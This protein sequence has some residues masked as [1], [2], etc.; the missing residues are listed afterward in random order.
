MKDQSDV[1]DERGVAVYT[2]S[3]AASTSKAWTTCSITRGWK[4]ASSAFN[5]PIIDPLLRA[6]ALFSAADWPLSFSLDHSTPG[7]AAW[8]AT[9]TSR[10]WNHRPSRSVRHCDTSAPRQ[11]EGCRPAIALDSGTA[12]GSETCGNVWHEVSL[13]NVQAS[14]APVHGAE[15][16]SRRRS[17][18]KDPGPT[19]K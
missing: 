17:M 1:V 10:P 18:R 11:S 3:A 12:S 7:P 14:H 6:N 4:Y 2:T 9:P 15:V 8:P 16:W 13:E 19:R 5:Q